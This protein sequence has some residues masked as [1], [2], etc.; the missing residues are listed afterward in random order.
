MLGDASGAFYVSWLGKA[1]R[2]THLPRFPNDAPRQNV[3]SRSRSRGTSMRASA[4]TFRCAFTACR[5]AQDDAD[6]RPLPYSCVC[7]WM[8]CRGFAGSSAATRWDPP[9]RSIADELAPPPDGQEDELVDPAHRGRRVEAARWCLGDWK[10]PTQPGHWETY[11]AVAADPAELVNGTWPSPTPRQDQTEE[12]TGLGPGDV[13]GV[14]EPAR[15]AASLPRY[16]I[17]LSVLTELRVGARPNRRLQFMVSEREIRPNFALTESGDGH[18]GLGSPRKSVITDKVLYWLSCH[19]IPWRTIVL[20]G[21]SDAFLA[22]REEQAR[23]GSVAP[24]VRP[25]S[26]EPTRTK[27]SVSQELTSQRRGSALVSRKSRGGGGRECAPG[28]DRASNG[29]NWMADA[30]HWVQG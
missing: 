28:R 12:R 17:L 16:I 30:D 2:T 24:T 23:S 9:A 19:P 1:I 6:E 13:A 21:F 29:S 20:P 22:R 25:Y 14:A 8:A 4:S 7:V 5:S 27:S 10:F 3:L 26:R 11:I 18:I 15:N